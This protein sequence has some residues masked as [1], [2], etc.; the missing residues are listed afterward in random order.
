MRFAFLEMK[1]VGL[2]ITTNLVSMSPK[3][4]NLINFKS[5]IGPK[6]RFPCL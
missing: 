6:S 5:T 3:I 1:Q 4:A 2:P